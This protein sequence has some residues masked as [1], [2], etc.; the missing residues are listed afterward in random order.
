MSLS[1]AKLIKKLYNEGIF[2][3]EDNTLKSGKKSPYYCD[4]R[5][6]IS[7]PELYQELVD[8]MIKYLETLNLEYDHLGCVP[9]GSLPF[10]TSIRI[11]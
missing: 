2:T 4:F 5:L 1:K 9:I 8:F 6:L 10:S 11:N 7:K 3:L